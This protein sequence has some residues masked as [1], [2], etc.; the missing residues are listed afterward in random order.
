MSDLFIAIMPLTFIKGVNRAFSEKVMLCLLMAAGLGATAAACVRFILVL[1]VYEE[2][3]SAVLNVRGDLL[4]GLE[5]LL[6]II[7][8][9]LPCLKGPAHNL[10]T[11]MGILSPKVSAQA[12]PDSFL[13]YYNHGTHIRRQI[14]LLGGDSSGKDGD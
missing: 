14:F 10:L 8:A 6:G 3:P 1:L 9:N 4:C 2:L 7:A 11:R 13:E 5:M 12:S